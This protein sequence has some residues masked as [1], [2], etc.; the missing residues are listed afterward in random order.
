MVT[1]VTISTDGPG[2]DMSEVFAPFY[3]AF[4]MSILLGGITIV[5]AYLYFPQSNDRPYVKY[6]AW[7]MLILD[8]ASSALVAQSLYYYLVP[9]FGSLLP[10]GSITPELSAECILSTIITFISQMYFVHQIY[11]F[12]KME[13]FAWPLTIVIT[14]LAFLAFAGG[15]GCVA[16]MYLFHHGVLSHRN[17]KFAIFFGLAKGFG[18][19][20]DVVATSAMC[21]LLSSANPG[22]SS[23]TRGVIRSL[24]H[25][26]VNRGILVTLIQ[27]LL[28]ITFFTSPTKLY[29]LA[30]HI[31]VTK[32]YA[33]TFFAMLNGREQIKQKHN[34]DKYS[35]NSGFNAS[36]LVDPFIR[37]QIRGDQKS[38]EMPT[39]TKTV[40]ISDV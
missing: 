30:F 9:H 14:I 18:S 4:V 12:R 28:L 34:K 37:E 20:T 31:N 5:Q 25:Y 22:V 16:T 39:V 2:M 23:Q 27:T 32:L 29:W 21:F 19:I 3:W 6:T 40:L 13:K 1:A 36:R 15:I 8:F 10:L 7:S 11:A 38:Y 35:V 24:I 33:N 17:G 26:V